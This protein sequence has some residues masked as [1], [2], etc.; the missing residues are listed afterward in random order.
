MVVVWLVVFTAPGWAPVI[1]GYLAGRDLLGM[2]I[3]FAM[4]LGLIIGL[5]VWGLMVWGLVTWGDDLPFWGLLTTWAVALAVS[6]FVTRAI[7]WRMHLVALRKN[8]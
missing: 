4:K 3:E 8:I 5:I 2:K 1:I 6:M 7:C